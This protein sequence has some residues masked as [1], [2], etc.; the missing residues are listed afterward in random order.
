MLDAPEIHQEVLEGISK[1]WAAPTPVLPD[2]HQP[3][4]K[5]V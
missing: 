2:T 5:G 4:L 1:Q 3:N